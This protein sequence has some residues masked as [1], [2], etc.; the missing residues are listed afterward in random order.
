MDFPKSIRHEVISAGFVTSG[1]AVLRAVH[2]DTR[3]GP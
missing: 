3:R 1:E 2:F